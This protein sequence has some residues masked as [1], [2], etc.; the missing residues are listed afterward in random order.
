MKNSPRCDGCAE[1]PT[2]WKIVCSCCRQTLQRNVCFASDPRS[3]SQSLMVSVAVSK[4]DRTGL[5]FVEPGVKVNGAYYRDVLVQHMLP[6]IRHIAGEFFIFQQ[7]CAP[8]HRAC[9]TILNARLLLSSRRICGRQTSLTSIQLTVKSGA[10]CSN[11]STR[12]KYRTWTMWGSVWLMCE[13]GWNMALLTQT[14]PF[15]CSGQSIGH[16]ECSLWLVN[17]LNFFSVKIC[18]K[19][20]LL[21]NIAWAKLP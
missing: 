12:R 19:H 6:G 15:M 1:E 8:A 16:F 2:E 10:W 14:F 13:T 17:L 4:L 7:D 5:I 20:S 18:R 9:E 21:V 3:A 11:E